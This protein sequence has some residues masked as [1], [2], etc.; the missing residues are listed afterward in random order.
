MSRIAFLYSN[1]VFQ[2][3][4]FCLHLAVMRIVLSIVPRLVSLRENGAVSLTL[5]IDPDIQNAQH[6]KFLG[7][8]FYAQLRRVVTATTYHVPL[9]WAGTTKKMATNSSV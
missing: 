7:H 9:S 6:V 3:S 8:R 1:L 2:I 5:L 4:H